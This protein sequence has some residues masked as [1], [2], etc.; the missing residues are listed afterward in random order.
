MQRTDSSPKM[1]RAITGLETGPAVTAELDRVPPVFRTEVV[2]ET[3]RVSGRAAGHFRDFGQR[4]SERFAGFERSLS[5]FA[6]QQRKL[7]EIVDAFHLSDFGE[8]LAV[9]RHV[10]R[11]VADE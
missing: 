6:R 2:T 3:Q 9:I 5:F 11:C 8:A 10:S 7:P 4:R 1:Q